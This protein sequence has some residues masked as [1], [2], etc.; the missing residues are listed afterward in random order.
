MIAWKEID[1]EAKYVAWSGYV[2]SGG[3]LDYSRWC[4]FMDTV[5]EKY[6]YS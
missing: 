1:E 5:W 6:G 2:E 4:D 3:P